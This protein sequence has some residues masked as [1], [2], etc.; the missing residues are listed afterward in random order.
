MPLQQISPIT[1]AKALLPGAAIAEG[2]GQGEEPYAHASLALVPASTLRHYLAVIRRYPLLSPEEEHALA[3]HYKQYGDRKAAHRLITGNLRLV[4]HTVREYQ[5]QTYPHLL[6]LIQEGNLGLIEAV[7]KFDPYRGIRFPSYAIWWIRAYILRYLMSNWRL[8]KIGTTRAQRKLFFGLRRQ[9]ARLEARGF[10]PEPTCVASQLGVKEE[11]V[12]EMEQRLAVAELSV[13]APLGDKERAP[14]LLDFIA[15]Q[16]ATP[17]GEVAGHEY[18]HRLR[19]KLTEFAHTLNDKEQAIFTQ[20]LFAETPL[21]LQE[22]AA[23]YG[24]S[25]ER[26]RQ[27]EQRVKQKLKNYL[28]WKFSDFAVLGVSF[29]DG[30]QEERA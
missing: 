4:V 27:L 15:D 26:V 18:R 17:E 2:L 1:G 13:D 30:Q 21:T 9:K 25:R 23:Q 6:D 7:G 12:V 24:I 22:I 28:C 11:D 29:I 14:T 3:V 16:R 10:S 20:R 19:E 5:G 8:I